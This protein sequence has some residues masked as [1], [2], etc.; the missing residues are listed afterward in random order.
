MWAPG[1][2]SGDLSLNPLEV[3]AAGDLAQA[4]RLCRA[5][6][7]KAPGDHEATLAL[8]IALAKS[9]RTLEAIDYLR[10]AVELSPTSRDSLLW[11]SDTLRKLGRYEEALEAASAAL[12]LFPGDTDF[13]FTAGMSL[14][15]LGRSQE[16]EEHLR[17]AVSQSVAP[18][19][20]HYLGVCLGRQNKIDEA[21]F[22]LEQARD[23][24]PRQPI[25]AIAIGQAKFVRKDLVGARKSAEE[26]LALNPRYPNANLLMAQVLVQEGKQIESESF[27]LRVLERESR[28]AE[29]N[30]LMGM[31]KQQFGQF[32]EAETFLDKALE[33]DPNQ[34]VAL[35]CKTQ[36]RKVMAE[37][38][39]LIDE[40]AVRAESPQTSPH[41]RLV[42]EYT[43]GKANDDLDRPETA[44]AHYDRA[45]QLGLQLLG[46]H[47]PWSDQRFIDLVD[48]T[49]ESFTP[50]SVADW[51]R[52]GGE[53]NRPI[54]VLGM[55][56]SGTT[57]L[58]QMLS[59][60]PS[61]VGA[62]ELSFWMDHSAESLQPGTTS[63][64]PGRMRTLYEN[65]LKVLRDVSPDADR[66]TD[67]MPGNSLLVGFIHCV[68]PNA[69]ILSLRRNLVDLASSIWTTFFSKSPEFGHHKGHIINVIRQHERLRDHWLKVIP[70]NRIMEVRYESLTADP[71]P[72]MRAVLEFCGLEWNDACVSPE[73]NRRFVTTPSVWRVSRP[74]DTA[75]VNKK[76][77]YGALLGEFLQLEGS[78]GVWDG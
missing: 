12:K 71:E 13:T 34:V 2:E 60:H 49:T 42:L 66:V 30:G 20:L 58:E 10:R 72:T 59:A 41:D 27:L 57:L 68:F 62:G 38:Q 52:F 16:A 55:I 44:M 14:L 36:S 74:V 37:D 18:Q 11:F 47:K 77:R 65:Y 51:S 50:E 61:V 29:A 17:R 56:R 69:R 40:L 48:R 23:M 75:S 8:G 46:D 24:E 76:R 3:L 26:A 28:S 15:G 78:D 31:I 67:K 39:G 1:Q 35:F 64:G 25:H 33:L 5:A 21:I 22:L 4:E 43:L 54:F 73:N 19:A 45:N 70:Q 7:E 63:L 32:E 6:L 9:R 53:S